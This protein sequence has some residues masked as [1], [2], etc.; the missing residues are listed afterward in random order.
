MTR[1]RIA[2][3]AHV[4][5]VTSPKGAPAPPFDGVSPPKRWRATPDGQLIMIHT[6]SM[7]TSRPLYAKL[8][9]DVVRD[10]APVTQVVRIPNVLV[11]PPALP[12]KNIREFLTLAKR[13]PGELV[14]A[15]T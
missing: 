15:S 6:A 14:F 7:I 12:V 5:G 11:V 8:G 4:C 9:Y 3:A 10:L 2:S 1:R 13:R